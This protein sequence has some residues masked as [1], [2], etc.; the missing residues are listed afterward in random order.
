MRNTKLQGKL[1]QPG[2]GGVIEIGRYI[3]FHRANSTSDY[4]GRLELGD[5]G[6]FY[7]NK[8]RLA[9]WQELDAKFWGN[10]TRIETICMF[11]SSING[12]LYLQVNWT[13]GIAY[14]G[15][16]STTTP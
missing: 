13:G 6:Y 12:K 2:N 7:S 3:D 14:I 1:D 9:L 5:D 16:D 10:N 4:D 15:V 11:T 8:G